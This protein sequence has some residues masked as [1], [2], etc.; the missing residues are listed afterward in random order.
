MPKHESHSKPKR[1]E[2]AS[3]N[4]L[5][6]VVYRESRTEWKRF[7]YRRKHDCAEEPSEKYNL[8]LELQ[9]RMMRPLRA[10]KTMNVLL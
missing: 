4:S 10:E 5:N 6:C 9:N 2:L 1:C 3:K 7:A 8:V